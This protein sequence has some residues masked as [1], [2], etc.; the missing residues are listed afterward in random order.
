M[1]TTEN[2]AASLASTGDARL[3]LFFKL[4]RDLDGAQLTSAVIESWAVDPLDTLRIAFH[5][6]D[7]RGGKGDRRPF[8]R[9]ISHVENAWP[10]WFEANFKEIP[11]F[12][13]WLDLVEL[14]KDL[15]PNGRSLVASFMAEQLKEDVANM[16]AER[17][18]SLLA[19][20][21]PSE[22]KRWSKRC[23]IRS[24]VTSHL[25]KNSTTNET[26]EK[27]HAATLRTKYISPL[28]AH[29][30]VV[31]R[32]MCGNTWNEI[33]YSSVPGCAMTRY[34]DAFRK[35]DAERFGQWV[36]DVTAGKATI[37]AGQVYPHELIA[38]IR[39]AVDHGDAVIEEQ[40][41]S[42][43]MTYAGQLNNTVV[44]SDVSG[45]MTGTPMD[46]SIALGILIASLAESDSPYYKR[47][48]TF[49]ESP[50]LHDFSAAKTLFDTVK[51]VEEM[52]W[53]GNTNLQAVFDLILERDHVPEN[54]LILSDMQFDAAMPD[55]AT[56][57][58]TVK[59]RFAKAEKRM[60]TIIFW[61]LRGATGDFPVESDTNG[62]VLLSGYSPAVMRLVLTGEKM[63]PYSIMRAAIDNERYAAI[64]SP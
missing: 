37:K 53:G 45:S 49:S 41:R 57:F 59:Q 30:K 50:T 5:G 63:S 35:H 51:S 36:A 17:P 3:N 54:V 6:R 48:I 32:Q 43:M 7:C 16:A 1:A 22:N 47:L 20:W 8:F 21:F 2:G 33:P 55:G 18:V 56:N 19:K 26:H 4:V 40:W 38:K 46:V 14:Y 62:V 24:D 34:R 42:I 12:G 61:N 58:E 23:N 10:T 25:F 11:E 44:V 39:A 31:E 13:R 27:G 60:P 52:D 64:K 29:I 15:S 9:I 28:R